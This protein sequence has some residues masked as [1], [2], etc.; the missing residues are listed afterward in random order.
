MGDYDELDTW[1]KCSNCG[2]EFAD[3]D[4]LGNKELLLCLYCDD[5]RLEKH[6]D[7]V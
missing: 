5:L 2:E 7:A 6:E 4:M 1:W 3:Y